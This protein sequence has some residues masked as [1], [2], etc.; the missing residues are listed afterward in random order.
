[1]DVLR[2]P[3][4]RAAAIAMICGQ[5]AMVFAMGVIAVHM[6]DNGH[7]LTDISIV[8]T[9]HVLGMFALSPL[10]GFWGMGWAA[11]R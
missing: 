8:M 10:V 2:S 6:N 4:S 11:S 3:D 1:M 7:S 9:V 5:A